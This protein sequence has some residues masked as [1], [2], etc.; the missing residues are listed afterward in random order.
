MITLNGASGEPPSHVDC[1]EYAVRVCPFLVDPSRQYN[2]RGKDIIGSVPI[3]GMQ[4]YNP[5]VSVFWVTKNYRVHGRVLM[6][7]NPVRVAWKREGRDAT[8]AE[9]RAALNASMAALR[10]L[11][12]DLPPEEAMALLKRAEE[13][14]PE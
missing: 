6:V 11:S 2:D 3:E 7:G 9:A 12:K 5:G 10:K 14:L 1:A 8:R 13:L 4:D